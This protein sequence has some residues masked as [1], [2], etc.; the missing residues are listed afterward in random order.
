MFTMVASVLHLGNITFE[1]DDKVSAHIQDK[2][3]VN[4]I[5]VSISPWKHNKTPSKLGP[6]TM[7]I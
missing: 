3:P 7:I 1:E 5:A 2:A 4:V 6:F